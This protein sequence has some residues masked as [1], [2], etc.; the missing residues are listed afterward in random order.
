MPGGTGVAEPETVD[1]YKLRLPDCGDRK[2]TFADTNYSP[3]KR[4]GLAASASRY[5]NNLGDNP[6]IPLLKDNSVST[7]LNVLL[8]GVVNLSGDI[9]LLHLTSR[10]ASTDS[11]AT[12]DNRQVIVSLTKQI[13]THSLRV[14]G[15]DILSDATGIEQKQ[16]SIEFGDS[17]ALKRLAVSGSLRCQRERTQ[18]VHGSQFRQRSCVD[19]REAQMRNWSGE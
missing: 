10:T 3:F 14:S 16:R 12:F 8:P 7:G 13:G 5:E 2:G 17:I 9:S 11:N 4:L 1:T 19:E 18:G 15:M 6:N